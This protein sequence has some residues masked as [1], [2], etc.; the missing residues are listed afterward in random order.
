MT[1]TQKPSWTFVTNHA[2]VLLCID[3]EP[4]IRVRDIAAQVGITERATQRILTE[5]VE[6]D[7]ITRARVGRRNTYTINQRRRLRHPL[8]EHQEIGKL[9]A[10]LAER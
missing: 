5:L 10:L 8:A 7:Y 1:E 6:A 2:A 3:R 4:G 9:L